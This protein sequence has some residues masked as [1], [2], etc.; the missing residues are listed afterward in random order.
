MN[1]EEL[2]LSSPLFYGN[3]G[4][5]PDKEGYLLDS[6][7]GFD[8]HRGDYWTTFLCPGYVIPNQ[9][10]KIHLSANADNLSV[11]INAAV[12]ACARFKVHFKV[13]NTASQYLLANS[14]NADRLSAGKLVT[15]Y[16]SEESFEQLVA[17]LESE[18]QDQEGPEI[19]TDL[20]SSV[21]C[22]HFR[23]GAFIPMK[24]EEGIYSVQDAEGR[25]VPDRREILCADQFPSDDSSTIQQA[26]SRLKN[27]GELNVTQV[28]LVKQSNAGGVFR[29]DFEGKPSY[30]KLGRWKAG[31]DRDGKDGWSRV[32]NEFEIL[33]FLKG[34]GFTAEPEKLIKNGRTIVAVMEDLE[35]DN[36]QSVKRSSFP[37]YGVQNG[38]WADYL[39]QVL[40][41]CYQIKDAIK[42]MHSKGVF[43]R[44][45]HV[46]NVLYSKGRISIV[47]FEDAVLDP[48]LGPGK[49]KAQG[50]SNPR[51]LNSAEADWYSFRQIVQDLVFG[52]TSINEFNEGGWDLRWAN[53][54]PSLL[55]E[56]DAV[57][58]L[59][60]LEEEARLEGF[61][62][63]SSFYPVLG[64]SSIERTD[65][66]SLSGSLNARYEDCIHQ[67]GGVS[68]APYSHEQPNCFVYDAKVVSEMLLDS[69]PDTFSLGQEFQY[70]YAFR[71]KFASKERTGIGQARDGIQLQDG[72]HE[73][74]WRSKVLRQLL[75]LSTVELC[76]E[77]EAFAQRC[78]ARIID[79]DWADGF[80]PPLEANSN[81][82]EDQRTGLLAGP[83]GIAWALSVWIDKCDVPASM[84]INYIR[85]SFENELK[86]YELSE[87][88]GLFAVQG[89]RLLPYLATGSSG[90][91]IV[92]S[93]LRKYRDELEFDTKAIQ[94]LNATN[95][96]FSVCTGLLNGM[97][98]LVLGQA[99]IQH[100]L[101][102]STV[103]NCNLI[104]RVIRLLPHDK[105]G[106]VTL[107]DAGLRYTFDLAEGACG[108][109]F[110][111][112]V[113]A[114]ETENSEP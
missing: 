91:G 18:L 21:P 86:F 79:E 92:L 17:F 49:S 20:P 89:S 26:K 95:A 76:R 55:T 83:L 58:L 84:M 23:Y 54:Y 66:A 104:K 32:E 103:S 81:S 88:G 7:E 99:G 75:G 41:I 34:S 13:V 106:P 10:W 94:L 15:I 62:K 69:E 112:R 14:K 93:H 46:R 22:V 111:T 40:N 60:A 85:R 39:S 70:D 109:L 4:I 72:R 90:F 3:L 25:M 47:D 64:E 53:P 101:G 5:E 78:I 113:L 59:K 97:A 11:V 52:N 44:D 65:L 51:L 6:V 33:N 35:A 9:G 36:L 100:F 42:Y 107:D 98:G 102:S 31:L 29:C 12:V 61:F 37:I 96:E 38:G 30:L 43:H 45:L 80:P 108:V 114:E 110:A 1:I 87:S 105:K 63:D 19:L 28:S 2:L 27:Y 24:N 82:W 77:D 71:R 68:L 16:P 8:R 50:Y 67:V 56:P 74:L 73:P 48:N 57:K